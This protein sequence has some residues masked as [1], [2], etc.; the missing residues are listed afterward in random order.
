[1]RQNA[2]RIGLQDVINGLGFSLQ[3][4]GGSARTIA[5][6]KD[7]LLPL[8][9]YAR[10]EGWSTDFGSLDAPKVRE[11]L[12]WVASRSQEYFLA[13]GAKRMRKARPSTAWHYYR[14]LRR[15][16]NWANEEGYVESSPLA[17]IHFKPPSAPP[18][19]G[20]TLDELKRLLAVCDLDS[21]T[22]ARFTGIRN[23]AMLLLFIDSGVR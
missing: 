20:Y 11:F 7:L 10:R 8:I 13:N 14:A 3:A 9:G 22:G 15:L 23:K 21:K 6:Y 5:Y 18:V 4:E 12:T 1:M 2:N 19:E 16:F 17:T